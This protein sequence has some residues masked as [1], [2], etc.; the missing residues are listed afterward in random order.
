MSEQKGMQERDQL[1]GQPERSSEEPVESGPLED[2][3]S[4]QEANLDADRMAR[5]QS[6]GEAARQQR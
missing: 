5:E 6:Q 1:G 2:Q 4:P 3:P